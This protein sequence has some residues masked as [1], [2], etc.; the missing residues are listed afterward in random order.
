MQKPREAGRPGMAPRS[1]VEEG[2]GGLTKTQ[3]PRPT[4]QE[5]RRSQPTVLRPKFMARCTQAQAGLMVASMGFGA[6]PPFRA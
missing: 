1:R 6:Q 5:K 4:V 2:L 3:K